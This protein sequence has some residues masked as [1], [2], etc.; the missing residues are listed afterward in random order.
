M[1]GHFFFNKYL[2]I[3]NKYLLILLNNL[4]LCV[5]LQ[6]NDNLLKALE[7][8]SWLIF[9]GVSIEAGGFLFNTLFTL[10][11][12]PAGAEKF[13]MEVNL[14]SL[15]RYNIGDYI[16][17]TSLMIIV[18]VLRALMFYYIVEVFYNKK[19]KLSQPFNETVKWL[20]LKIAYVALAI[21][22]FSYWGAK[23]TQELVHR[24]VNVPDLQQ[25]RLAGADVWLFM[26]VVLFVFSQIFKKGIEL[27]NE[28]D[29]TV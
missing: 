13:W 10:F 22:L 14:S 24:G 6:K 23:Y 21:G 5:M 16:V 15:Y 18:A 7:V 3:I 25:L 17:V 8:V 29:L 19:L 28:N 26:G 20:I 12:N 1:V 4:N 2:L 27:Q 9:I 11:F